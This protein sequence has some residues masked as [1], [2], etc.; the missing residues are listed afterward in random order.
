MTGGIEAIGD[1]VTGATLARAVE[2]QHGEGV[3]DE[4]SVCLNCGTGLI[5]SHCHSCGQKAKVHRTISAFW[6]DLV[7]AVFH[8]DGKFFRTLPMLAW[9]PGELT[10]RYV[11]GERARFVS[12]LAL[13]LFSVFLMFAVFNWLGPKEI[14][15]G[16]DAT[17]SAS[18]VARELASDKAEIRAEIKTLEADKEEAKAGGEPYA[19]ADTQ[20]ARQRKALADLESKAAGQL[21]GAEIAEQKIQGGRLKAETEVARLEADVDS[22]RKSGKPTSA[23]QQKLDN[24]RTGV[25]LLET[26]SEVVRNGRATN[27]GTINLGNSGLNAAVQHA[28]EN[29]QLLLYKM[30]SN[31][32]KFSWALIPMSVP[33]LWLLFAWRPQFRLFDHAVF[34]TYSL[35]F[36]LALTTVGVILLQFSLTGTIGVLALVLLPPVHMYRQLK[37][38]YGLS[39]RGALWRTAALTVFAVLGLS[40][41][42]ILILVVGISS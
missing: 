5:G 10:R 35:C 22:A 33:F 37:Q 16:R 26:A 8:F 1:V 17:I 20:I 29:P 11:H 24:A 9:K 41:F 7:H 34:V 15:M 21:R 38:A 36:M 28:L 23:L 4:A 14:N 39:R 6:H 2:P 25:T 12:P 40:L 19:W 3:A 32:Y 18:D 30:Q 42:A 13:F 27:S 31:A